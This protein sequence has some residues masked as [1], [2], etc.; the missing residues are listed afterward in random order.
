LSWGRSKNPDPIGIGWFILPLATAALAI[1]SLAASA[2]AQ[3][4]PADTDP[5]VLRSSA[6]SEPAVGATVVIEAVV[7][8]ASAVTSV[9]VWYRPVG[10]GDFQAAEASKRVDDPRLYEAGV[11]LTSAFQDG[12]EYYVDATDEFGNR[13]TDGSDAVPYL[14][15]VRA[16]PA[17]SGLETGTEAP[18]P[19]PWWKRRWVWVTVVAVVAG[20]VAVAANRHDETGTVV[21]E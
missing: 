4:T 5:P 19:R 12:L 9:K 18:A 2:D 7:E 13:G 3:P 1:A 14:I 17:L 20:G 10:G 16:L 21:V 15:E 6:P 11:V 8:D